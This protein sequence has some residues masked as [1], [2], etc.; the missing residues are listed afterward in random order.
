MDI[1]LYAGDT[2]AII[3]TKGGY[4]TNLADR[5][6]DIFFP[7]RTLGEKVRGGCHV[8]LPNFG[9]GGEHG[10]VQHGFGRSSEWEVVRRSEVLVELVLT[11]LGTYR[12]T[13]FSLTYELHDTAL[14]MS[15]TVKNQGNTSRKVSP[16]FHPY[17]YCGGTAVEINGKRYEDLAEFGEAVFVGSDTLRIQIANRRLLLHS[18]ELLSW[19]LWTDQLGDYFCVEPTQS[20]FAF[21]EDITRADTI[22]PGTEK[23]YSFMVAW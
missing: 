3:A 15:L 13:T 12:D 10:L 21:A 23:S 8:C 18:D 7:K 17:F 5:S 22:E 2:K 4:V 11:G 6:G 16:G 9:P 20:G 19:A 1:E 14:E